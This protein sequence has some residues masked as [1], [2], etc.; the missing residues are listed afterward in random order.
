[1]ASLTQVPWSK[2]RYDSYT[3]RR[4]ASLQGTIHPPSFAWLVTQLLL[5]VSLCSTSSYF[6]LG[7]GCIL[8]TTGRSSRCW[9][10]LYIWTW[11][12]VSMNWVECLNYNLQHDTSNFLLLWHESHHISVSGLECILLITTSRCSRWW[13]AL[14]IYELD[15]LWVW[16]GRGASIITYIIIQVRNQE[17]HLLLLL[18]LT[19]RP[20]TWRGTKNTSKFSLVFTTQQTT[21]IWRGTKNTVGFHNTTDNTRPFVEHYTAIW[22]A[23]ELWAAL[24]LGAVGH[25]CGR[26]RVMTKRAVKGDDNGSSIIS[27]P[28]FTFDVHAR[29]LQC[30]QILNH[31]VMSTIRLR[32][33]ELIYRVGEVR[34]CLY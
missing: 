27:T 10:A 9:K 19:V 29:Q 14:Y 8:M 22:A 5:K 18:P 25:R 12:Y 34:L 15:L 7:Y 4:D 1:M 6:I 30:L 16:T 31:S 21:L 3:L 26:W 24:W 11:S 32:R 28:P 2:G 13:N 33:N 23:H 17:N 20:R